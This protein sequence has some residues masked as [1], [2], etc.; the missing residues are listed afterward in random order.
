MPDRVSDTHAGRVQY[1]PAA[2]LSRAN[3]CRYSYRRFADLFCSHV[4]PGFSQAS[5][6][7]PPFASK[8]FFNFI[9]CSHVSPGFC[10]GIRTAF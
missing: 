8:S 2:K 9:C 4:M 10:H 1:F 7:C 5:R 6:G 3:A